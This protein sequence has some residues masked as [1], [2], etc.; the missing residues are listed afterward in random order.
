MANGRN[1]TAAARKVIVSAGE[2]DV[3]RDLVR[4]LAALG[5]LDERDHAVEERPAR[6]LGDLDHE[7]VREQPRPA[8]D[9]RAVAARL[10]DDRGGLARDRGLVD[11]AD[12]LDDLAVGG[13]D[14]TRL[15]DDDVAA[16][17]VGRRH[18]L[19]AAGV[20]A[21]VRDRGRAR[22]AERVRL[23]LA[24]PFGDRLGEVREQN[25]EPEPERDRAR[26]PE[27][28]ALARTRRGRGRRSPS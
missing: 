2:E 23:R 25:G 20:R 14:L 10:A 17:E 18:L 28:L 11:R 16:P 8:G 9:R 19:E 6:L 26:E 1:V 7:S 4:R 22:G 21:P 13:N 3:E 12:A 5:A 27:R 24:P 15:D